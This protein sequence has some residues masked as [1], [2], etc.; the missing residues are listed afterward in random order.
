MNSYVPLSGTLG[1]L[2]EEGYVEDF[3]LHQ[4]GLECP[5]KQ[6]KVFPDDFKVDK[7]FRFEGSNNPSDQAI[8]YAI[9]SDRYQ[10][11]G[12]LVT[13]LNASGIYSEPLTDELLQKLEIKR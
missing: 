11:K 5:N 8:L 4:N 9:S 10:V 1:Q 13:A 12:V 7:Y 3:N 2:R 6:L